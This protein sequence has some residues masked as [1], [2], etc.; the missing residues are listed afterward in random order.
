MPTREPIASGSTAYARPA[1]DRRRAPRIELL[2]ELHG[3]LVSLDVA[4]EVVDISLN[5]ALI[6]TPFAV[7]LGSVHEFKLTLGDESATVIRG[8]AVRSHDFGAADGGLQYETGF[9]FVEDRG[10]EDVD[11]L[12][13]R[14]I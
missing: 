10:N 3:H 1:P 5:G 7:P 14:L 9:Q 6:R 4:I 2:G 8:I 11:A 12:I 13:D